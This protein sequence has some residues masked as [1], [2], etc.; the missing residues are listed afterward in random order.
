MSLAALD[1]AAAA[2]GLAVLGAFH[3]SG[4]D[5]VPVAC[6]TLALVGPREPG[7]WGVFAASPEHGDGA[8][9]PLDRWSERVVGGLARRFGA[10][11][12]FPFGG[13]P[14]HPFGRWALRTGRVWS[15]P[16]G[17]LVH[18]TAG[19]HVSFRGA[20]AL[21]GRLDLPP[22]ATRPCDGC[23]APC[24]AAC[25]VGA[26]TPQGYDVPA[27]RTHLDSPAG[28]DCMERGCHVRRAC[29][30]GAG[31]RPAAQAAFHMAAFHPRR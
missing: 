29:P 24:R 22:P 18:A 21:P 9:D 26:L 7:F 6:G 17:L 11:A 10:V 25:P 2:T 20:L 14:H 1:A 27:C 15:S 3:P 5:A 23:D 30:V 13:P 12:L 19:L 4:G 31:R 8:A 28:A 16:V